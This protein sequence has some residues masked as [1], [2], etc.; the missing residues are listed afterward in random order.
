M[1]LIKRLKN[2]KSVPFTHSTILSYL[3]NYKNPNDKI[4]QMVKNEEIIRVKQSL[5]VVG[6]IYSDKNISKG[7]LANLIYGPSYVSMEYALSFYGLIPERVY[8]ITSMTTKML[9][10][11]DTP[12]GRFTYIKSPT[13]I[14][15][16]D[17]KIVQNE[18]GTSFMIASAEKAL[19]DKLIFTKKLGITSV[20]AMSEYLIDD[21]RIDVEELKGFNLDTIKLCMSCGYKIKLLQYLQKVIKKVQE[22]ELC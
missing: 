1:K 14:Y 3:D 5:Y 9:K 11:Y 19:C 10:N 8:E 13:C 18:D 22:S 2:F 20:N 17:I 4:K 6:D 16:K 7:L 12:F 15:S 21:L